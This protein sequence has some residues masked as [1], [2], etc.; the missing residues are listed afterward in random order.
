MG[1]APIHPLDVHW[2]ETRTRAFASPGPAGRALVRRIEA[3]V[4]REAITRIDGLRNGRGG[5]GS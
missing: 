3:K 2:L 4:G 5:A 1:G